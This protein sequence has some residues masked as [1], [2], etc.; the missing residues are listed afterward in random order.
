V[1]VEVRPTA[2]PD[3]S[4]SWNLNRWLLDCLDTV[5]ALGASQGE[6][7]HEDGIAEILE[8]TT[9]ALRR[10]HE[11]EALAFLEADAAGLDFPLIACDPPAARA[12]V[13]AEIER[14]IG[15]GLFGWAL[16]RRHP[17]LA[18]GAGG[19]V[20]LHV[21]ATRSHVVGM[22]VGL[23]AEPTGFVPDASQKLVSVLLMNCASML[24]SARLWQ[25]VSAYHRNLESVIA[26]R[27][28]EL[29]AAKEA[30]LA[31]S[32]AKSEFLAN[33]SHEIRTP[34]NGVLGMTALLLET[35]LTPEQRE[36]A[37]TVSRSGGDLLA[38]INDILDF[39]KIEAG[40]MEI[41]SV[42][43]EPGQLV[44]DVLR[45]LQHRAA[46]RGIALRREHAGPLPRLGGDPLRLRQIVVN[47]VDNAIKF[48][49]QGE[50]VVRV[51][52][53]EAG[54]APGL[55][56]EVADTGMGIPEAKRQDIFHQ[57][58]QAD[59]STT[60][61]HGGTGLGLT[62]CRQLALLMGGGIEVESRVGH[63]STFRVTLPLPRAAEP[64]PTPPAGPTAPVVRGERPWRILL[65][66]DNP[67]NQ[68]VARRLLE[69]LGCESVVAAN[70]S[71]AV[72]RF[73]E[74]GFD[75]VL[76]DCQMPDVDGYEATAEI[77]R[78]QSGAGHTPIVAMT[79]NAMQGDRERCL[80]AGMD[81]YIS[82]PVSRA[83]L[84]ATL[85][86]WLPAAG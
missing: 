11:F 61:K 74:G 17:V 75:L 33:M 81:D 9:T 2:G 26:E 1:S 13:E 28:R 5:V 47:L 63:G 80:A 34:M 83:T 53:T 57:F 51:G 82:K 66:E 30:A 8:R 59:S 31:A 4:A 50:V 45:L 12:A 22:F 38:I 46:A 48:T 68:A 77:R 27:T 72:Q 60:R 49:A 44:D 35:S 62:I 36:Y 16:Q 39:S 20:V 58:T 78:A 15:A 55:V 14:A 19:G 29:E 67:V 56:L 24:R 73:S 52:F 25:E 86:R 10:V 76:M 85:A 69:R 71:E 41:E 54:A 42:P 79:A 6:P 32:R 21:L 18:A 3:P 7:S 23:L 64:A 84:E 65:A 37:E 43:F 70:G 40:K